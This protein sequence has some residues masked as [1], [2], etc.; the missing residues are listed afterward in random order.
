VAGGEYALHEVGTWARGPELA[1]K[2]SAN[3]PGVMAFSGDGR[4]L[5]LAVAPSSIE[6]V[7]LPH[8]ESLGRLD[9]PDRCPLVALAFSRD[10]RILAAAGREN[11]AML[12]D[13]GDLA[14]ELSALKLGGRLPVHPT[15]VPIPRSVKLTIEQPESN[16]P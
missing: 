10:G 13:L 11:L 8:G 4:L 1:R 2:R 6:L 5:A 14:E 16:S 12:W 15:A 9:G 3:Q 7:A